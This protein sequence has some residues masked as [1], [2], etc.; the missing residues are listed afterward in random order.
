MDWD[1]VRD[2]FPVTEQWIFLNHAAVAPI[3]RRAHDRMCAWTRDQ[4]AG[5]S[6]NGG[7]WYERVEATR[8]AAARLLGVDSEEI[9]LVANTS[10][11]IGFV[12]EGVRWARGDNVVTAAEEYPSNL[13]PWMNLAERGVELRAVET[14]DGRIRP[15]DIE[16]A[17]DEH[18][19]LITLSVVEYASG[20]RND[21]GAV[22]EI[23]RQRDAYFFVDA[24]QGLGALA[25]D[26]RAW[27]VDFLAADSHKWMLGPEGA[28][29]FY[30]RRERIDEL[31]ATSVGWNSVVNALD[32]GAIDFTLR[33]DAR[34]WEA[35]SANVVGAVGMGASIE[36][37]LDI[38]VDRIERRVI[39]LTDL[40]CEALTDAGLHV[41]S[42]R[43]EGDKSGIVSFEK[44]GVDSK[45]LVEAL[46][47][48]AIVGSYRGGRARL[49]PHFYNTPDELMRVVEVAK[50]VR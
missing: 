23:C 15:A 31:R 36:L 28:G 38:G 21:L 5:G 14:R 24:I 25:M 35:G 41:A 11:G 17:A 32:F 49:S 2:E 50:R 9:A 29:V 8:A 18:T 10:T 33:P 44:P 43:L 34:R 19:R 12:A 47:S 16:A 39:E 30:V 45:K 3:S 46:A 4:L 13:Y 22:G 48:E 6:V 1:A 27:G 42:S 20:F 40:L 7:A 37:I 26:V